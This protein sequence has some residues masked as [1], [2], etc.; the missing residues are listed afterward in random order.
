MKRGMRV[1]A[2][3]VCLLVVLVS[4]GAAQAEREVYVLTVDGAISSAT[5]DYITRGIELAKREEAH[6]AVIL[7]D[8]PGGDLTAML[9]IME[10]L[11]NAEVPVIVYVWPRGGMAASAGA[12]I[13]L[14]ASGAAMA[15]HTTIGAAHPVTTGEVEVGADT[16]EKIAN[17]MVERA[18][19]LAARRGQ[20]AV[21]WV[22]RAI[23][24]S[25]TASEQ[26][27][28]DMG[29]IDAVADDLDDLLAQFDG[30]TVPLGTGTIT[31]H[32]A[33]AAVRQVPMSPVEQV[34]SVLINPNV[35][36][37]LLVLGIQLILLELSAPG[38]WVAGLLGVLCLALA[39]Y[40]MRILPLNWL[41]LL[42]IGVSF[43]LFLL[44]L[45]TPG[46]EALTFAGI[47]TLIAG[48]LILFN[49]PVGSPYG[50]VS[51]PLVVVIGLVSGG[52]FAF[53]AAKGLRAQRLRP[54]TGTGVLIGQRG[55]VR[56]PLDPEGTV[57]VAGELWTAVADDA[58]EYTAGEYTAGEYTAGEYTRAG[59]VHP[60]G[61][62][63]TGEQVEVVDVAGLRLRVRRSAEG[64]SG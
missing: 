17:V 8:T 45:R 37:L 58:G 1:L 9:Q 51:V 47:G 35:A 57:W 21:E 34:L 61:P 52:F 42:L 19:A 39:A 23:R 3:A 55:I 29:L 43:I 28:L 54:V 53:I 31:L 10:T 14:A 15:P 63:A 12:L 16:V 32:T 11:E 36:F 26:E 49:L 7:L 41:G 25:E 20:A 60:G 64:Q 38:G 4:Y 33:G 40:A 24:A 46:V 59:K 44:D 13:T 2:G 5:A 22:E 30:R 50:R 56:S 6:A 48:A 62:L 18:G 27:A